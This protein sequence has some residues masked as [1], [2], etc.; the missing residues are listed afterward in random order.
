MGKV[1]CRIA[2]REG[3]RKNDADPLY[4]E[5][6]ATKTPEISFSEIP[7]I[8]GTCRAR[9]CDLLNVNQTLSQLS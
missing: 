1:F 5:S 8:S 6:S 3:S 2:G 9:T 7:G 4:R